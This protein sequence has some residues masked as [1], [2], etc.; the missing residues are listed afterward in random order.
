MWVPLLPA[1]LKKRTPVTLPAVSER[2]LTPNV[3]GV[4]S[5]QGSHGK[6]GLGQR[7]LKTA[8]ELTVI[9]ADADL[10]L[11]ACEVAVI[12]T[13]AELVTLAGAVYSPLELILPT[14]GLSDHVTAVLEVFVTVA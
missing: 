4:S 14:V 10:L 8:H 2:N 12:V 6:T 9:V 13:L 3:T 7:L 11:S 5:Y 1:P